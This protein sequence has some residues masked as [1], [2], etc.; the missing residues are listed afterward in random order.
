MKFA[1]IASVL[2]SLVAADS[3]VSITS[4][5]AGTKL[6]AGQ[7]VIISWVNPTVPTISQ[8]VLAKG[9]STALQPM[10]A[11]AQNVDAAAGHFTWKIPYEIENGAEYAFEFGTSPD[12]AFAGPFSIEGGVGGTLPPQTLPPLPAHPPAILPRRPALPPVR[13][14]LVRLLLPNLP[15][16]HPHPP[17]LLHRSSL[18]NLSWPWPSSLLSLN[19]FNFLPFLFFHAIL[20]IDPSSSRFPLLFSQTI[21]L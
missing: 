13:L 20:Y 9:P 18:P 12:L 14:L 15:R 11:I 10:T 7:D 2:M 1:L 5:L 4:P 19:S 8:I 6:K 17:L 16:P 3:I 21:N